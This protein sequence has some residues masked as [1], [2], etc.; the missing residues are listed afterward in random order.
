MKSNRKNHEIEPQI[1]THFRNK[2]I[3]TQKNQEIQ[4]PSHCLSFSSPKRSS[5]RREIQTPEIEKLGNP[6]NR[7]SS[8]CII[9]EAA[10]MGTRTEARGGGGRSSVRWEEEEEG[11]RELKRVEF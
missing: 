1:Q 8:S 6:N 2:K 5:A 4:T 3:Q 11:A 7:S 10:A 9:F